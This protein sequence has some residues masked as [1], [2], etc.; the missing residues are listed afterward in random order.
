[1]KNKKI[2]KRYRQTVYSTG[3]NDEKEKVTN[4][5]T[6]EPKPKPNEILEEDNDQKADRTDEELSD[7]NSNDP[8]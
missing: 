5:T 1:M 4:D 6:P 7:S 3:A 8:S 2:N